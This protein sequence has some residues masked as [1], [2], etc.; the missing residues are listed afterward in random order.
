MDLFKEEEP[1]DKLGNLDNLNSSVIKE[2]NN[3]SI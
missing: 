1:L 2:D 3:Y